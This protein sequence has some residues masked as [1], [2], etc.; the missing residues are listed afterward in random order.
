M[1][2]KY[3]PLKDDAWEDEMYSEIQKG[4]MV[5]FRDSSGA[6]GKGRTVMRGPAGW[7]V[8]S[9]VRGMPQVVQ[10]DHNYLGHTPAKE[11]ELDHF[12][13]FLYGDN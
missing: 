3:F 1:S 4:D 10:E 8:K 11:R 9:Q 12:G 7:V 6:I 5:W 2:E 13:D